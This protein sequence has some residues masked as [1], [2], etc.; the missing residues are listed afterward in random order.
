MLYSKLGGLT[1]K[2][3]VVCSPS[4]QTWKPLLFVHAY[5]SFCWASSLQR[6]PQ[7]TAAETE[8]RGLASHITELRWPE[9]AEDAQA[10][11]SRLDTWHGG[12][13]D[14]SVCHQQPC[15]GTWWCRTQ[16]GAGHPRLS[17]PKCHPPSPVQQETNSSS[18]KSASPSR[19]SFP[20]RKC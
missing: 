6:E 10:Q 14:V 13:H 15:P 12:A 8:L 2:T 7:H 18:H 5:S 1:N 9:A 16:Q 4:S 3:A 19:P 20:S 11:A 17:T